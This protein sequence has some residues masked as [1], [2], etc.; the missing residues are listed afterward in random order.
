MTRTPARPPEASRSCSPCCSGSA[1]SPPARATRRA[2]TSSRATRPSAVKDDELVGLFRL[3]PGAVDGDQLTGTWFRMLQPGGDVEERPVH[4]Q[5]RLA[6][7]RRPGHAARAR[8][9]RRAALGGLPVA[10]VPGVRR[11]RQLAGRRHHGPDPV[12]RRGVQH[13][14]QPRSTRR[15]R[16]RSPPPTVQLDDGKLTADLSSWAASWNNQEFNQG[17]PKPVLSTDAKAPGQEQAE[18][19]WDWVA[20]QVPG[21]G[22]RSPRPPATGATGTYDPETGAFVLE[23]TSYIEGGPFNG[24]TGL[25]HLEGVFEP[26]GRAPDDAG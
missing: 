2:A 7:R 10:A 23:W 13:L 3:T 1:S 22:A 17:A 6:G 8:H 20:Q 9:L 15:P 18:Q 21:G 24:F 16:P 4:G 14:D 19:V 5:R 12:L 26:S 11:R 25:W